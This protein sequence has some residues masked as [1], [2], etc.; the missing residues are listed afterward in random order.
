M[1]DFSYRD[2]QKASKALG[3]GGRGK[4]AELYWRVASACLGKDGDERK[5]ALAVVCAAV[6]GG[7][8]VVTEG[9]LRDAASAFAE[10]D[11]GGRAQVPAEY[12]APLLNA[13][14]AEKE[15]VAEPAAETSPEGEDME[16]VMTAPEEEEEEVAETPAEE[17]PKPKVSFDLP[18]ALTD[19]AVAAPAPAPGS[20][21]KSPFVG[22]KRTR[23][24]ANTPSTALKSQPASVKRRRPAENAEEAAAA[25]SIALIDEAVDKLQSLTSSTSKPR[26][27]RNRGKTPRSAR[28]VNFAKAHEKAFSAQKSIGE[29]KYK[30]SSS[31]A[32]A[33]SFAPKT[34]KQD[35]AA[36][37][38]AKSKKSRQPKATKKAVAVTT[39]AVTPGEKK[40]AAS[41]PASATTQSGRRKTG[42]WKAPAA[43]K[44]K[45]SDKKPTVVQAF[46]LSFQKPK[47][48]IGKEFTPYSGTIARLPAGTPASV[49]FDRENQA[50]SVNRPAPRS[51]RRR[52]AS[53]EKSGQKNKLPANAPREPVKAVRSGKKN[54]TDRRRQLQ[55]G[56]ARSKRA[57]LRDAKRAAAIAKT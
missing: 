55:Q 40:G 31:A 15:E 39:P 8:P 52:S 12:H 53:A 27:V 44:V 6:G 49:V 17:D 23:T 51:G 48:A 42:T 25:T 35:K 20:S 46:N 10:L 30:P 16:L 7:A 26:A 24:P 54:A 43:F 50:A 28:R 18:P 56:N 13:R 47:E 2:L 1:E 19:P 45:K 5:E 22:G 3:L 37:N 33:L 34:A 21:T 57:S 32:R 11:D 4:K 36:D 38:G 14:N 41:R 9:D 29:S